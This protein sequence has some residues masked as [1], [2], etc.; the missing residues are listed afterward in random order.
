MEFISKSIWSRLRIVITLVAI[1][2][3]R[4]VSAQL[5][6]NEIYL[7]DCTVSMVTNGL[8][9]PAKTALD[10][11]ITLQCAD[12]TTEFIIIPFSNI[13]LKIFKTSPKT[14]PKDKTNIFKTCN[15]FVAIPNSTHITDVL[16]ESFKHIDP[17]KE[18]RIYL[19]TD[20]KPNGGDTPAKVADSIS[21][22][23]GT[24]KN[25]KLFYVALTEGVI[26]SEIK[27]AID[28]CEDAYIVQCENKVIPQIIAISS[29]VY[30]NIEELSI[31]REIDFSLPGEYELEIES[32][33]PEFE[34]YIENGK[35]KNGKVN[36]TFKS[37]TGKSIDELHEQLGGRDYVFQT[38]IKCKDKRFFIAN[39][40]VKIHISDE[41]K[42]DLN[43]AAGNPQIAAAGVTWHDSFL[44][45][46]ES[47]VSRAVWDLSP[48]F[49]HALPG[50]SAKF[51][52]AQTVGDKMDFKCFFN[53]IEIGPDSL[54][55]IENGK[56]AVIEVEFFN[57]A[58]TGKRYFN[59]IPT[60]LNEVDLINGTPAD[61]NN[62]SLRTKYSTECNPLKLILF[63]VAIAILF[64]LILWIGYFNRLVFPRFKKG[65][66]NIQDPYFAPIR[67]TGARMVVITPTPKKQGWFD[68]I[69]K[70]KIIFHVNNLW[71]AEV[72]ITP[73][74]KNMRFRCPSNTLTITPSLL[75][76]RGNN[77]TI[78][79]SENKTKITININ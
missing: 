47:P 69:M 32:S 22:W 42:T 66:I 33:D 39:P 13:P 73:S 45:S 15:G 3:V 54:F 38:A 41:V 2:N 79:S 18:N 76:T 27:K 4:D 57:D 43:L 37:R 28:N 6:K 56:P 75:L 26:D 61:V 20:G 72:I 55:V 49:I 59:I 9:E 74:G 46:D 40:T 21:A 44:W 34:V 52:F 8:W 68:R 29:D 67:T 65:I 19:L 7:L 78:Q 51:K 63:W 23:C 16:I 10:S 48:K 62:I 70:G 64:I 77:Y 35:S 58:T 17:N 53:S 31:P 5:E 11:T 12:P 14:Y 24:H 60:E 71:P 25:C 36:L 1:L 30:T 50:S